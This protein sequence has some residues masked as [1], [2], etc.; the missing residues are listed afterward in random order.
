MIGSSIIT[1]IGALITPFLPVVGAPI[2]Y[3]GMAGI[4][5]SSATSFGGAV[6]DAVYE[7]KIQK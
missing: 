3:A 7:N 5:A 6:A 1:G 2:A 4:A